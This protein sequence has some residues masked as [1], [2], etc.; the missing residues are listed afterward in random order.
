MWRRIVKTCESYDCFAVLGEQNMENPLEVIE[1]YQIQ[2][3]FRKVGITS[4]YK[5]AWVD[6]NFKTLESTQFA[7]TVL[8]NR[9]LVNGRLF[10]DVDKAKEW[11]FQTQ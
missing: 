9:G 11:L 2:D 1:N 7:E 3:I 4:Q 5:I 10:T 6:L 8:L